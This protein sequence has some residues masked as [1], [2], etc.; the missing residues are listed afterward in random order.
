MKPHTALKHLFIPHAGNEYKPHFFREVS[1]AILVFVSIFMLGASMGSSFFIHKTV[2]GASIAANTLVDLTNETR[3]AFNEQPLTRNPL[4]AEAAKRKGENMA[5]EGYFAHISPKGTTPWHWFK[6]AGYTFLYAG[7]NL[8]VDFTESDEVSNAWMNSPTHR[9]NLLNVKFKE[10]GIAVTEGV[11]EGNP[12]LFVVQMFGT[13]ALALDVAT[14]TLVADSVTKTSHG[15]QSTSSRVTS[16]ES[17]AVHNNMATSSNGSVLAASAYQNIIETPELA[18]V[19]N[20]NATTT[21]EASSVSSYA[22]PWYGKVVT[23]ASHYIDV[24]YKILACIVAVALLTMILVE[25]K[26]QH[27]KHIVYGVAVLIVIALCVVIN[28]FV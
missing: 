15:T 4:L 13:P 9:A 8:A 6:E 22:S 1:V 14:D 3:V 24:F 18:I 19:R 26:H 27:Y 2:K 21:E 5:Q 20:P 17:G 28:R 23:F 10:I 16:S 7:E 12:T 11:Y 25:Y